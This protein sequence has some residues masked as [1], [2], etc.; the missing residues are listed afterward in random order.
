MEH[1]T[2][3]P[4]S[5]YAYDRCSKTGRSRT[6]V[7]ERT[8]PRARPAGARMHRMPALSLRQGSQHIIKSAA[9]VHERFHRM[10]RLC[11]RLPTIVE[12]VNHQEPIEAA[13]ASL[14]GMG[15]TLNGIRASFSMLSATR[16]VWHWKRLGRHGGLNSSAVAIPWTAKRSA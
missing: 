10:P 1:R 6:T 13:P 9:A 12:E 11:T 5:L 16:I 8:N 7:P 15:L 2:A 14:P 3:L 4:A